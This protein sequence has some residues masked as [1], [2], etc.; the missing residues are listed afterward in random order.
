MTRRV[1]NADGM[2]P[3]LKIPFD[4]MTPEDWQRAGQSLD[5]QF[6]LDA[7]LDGMARRIEPMVGDPREPFANEI[8]RAARK[9]ALAIDK[10]PAYLLAGDTRRAALKGIEIGI[11]AQRLDVL[12]F[13]PDVRRSKKVV[14]GARAGHEIVHGNSEE[15]AERYAEYV[16]AFQEE[17]RPNR[18]KGRLYE[19]L[20][21]R[22]GVSSKTIQRAVEKAGL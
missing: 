3:V 8:Q 22:F 13:E 2:F 19:K 12:Q 1:E 16:A 5:E 15:K 6:D 9:L 4:E 21:T 7:C 14:R 18:T 10:L 11:L 17:W 20:A